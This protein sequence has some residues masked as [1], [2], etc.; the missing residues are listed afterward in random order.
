MVLASVA[1]TAARV[2]T[3][4]HANAVVR[5]DNV[6]VSVLLLISLVGAVVVR[7]SSSY[8]RG[9]PHERRYVR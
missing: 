7:Y 1:I 9:E 6:T 3:G 8:L 5:V 4:P 2:A